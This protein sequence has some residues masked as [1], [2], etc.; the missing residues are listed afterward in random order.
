[1]T[2]KVAKKVH[3]EA[4]KLPNIS[5]IEA[6]VI[7]QQKKEYEKKKREKKFKKEAVERAK[8]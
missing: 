6:E 1:M 5:R 8:R 7:A 2:S 3:R 4:S